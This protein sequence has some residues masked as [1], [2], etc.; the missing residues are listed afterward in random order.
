MQHYL[1]CKYVINE[2]RFYAVSA[3]AFLTQQIGILQI[4]S[5]VEILIIPML[6]SLGCRF[7]VLELT[8]MVVILGHC[9]V[10]MTASC[11]SAYQLI[12]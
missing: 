6:S 2:R 8:H 5:G 3:E 1:A 4:L 12:Q 7:D 9:Y 10:K 11:Y